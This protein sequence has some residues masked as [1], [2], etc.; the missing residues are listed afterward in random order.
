MLMRRTAE[1]ARLALAP[2]VL[3]AFAA[4]ASVLG[5][6]ERTLDTADSYPPEGYD[7]CRPGAD[8][9]GCLDV[10]HAECQARAACSAPDS[11]GPCGQCVCGSCSEPVVDCQLDPGCAAI[12]EC[13]QGSR[14]ELSEGAASCAQV[15]GEV[16]EDNGGVRGASFLA[17]A[18][19]RT[20]AVTSSCLSCLPASPEPPATCT[21]ANGCDACDSCFRQCL[22][23]GERFGVCQEACGEDA[24]PAAC[25][26][27]D[28]C[29]GCDTCFVTCACHGG[30]FDECTAE[31]QAPEPCTAATSCADCGDCVKQCECQGG[32]TVDCEAACAPPSPGEC[33]LTSRG[34]RS[35]RCDGCT[36]CVAD[37]VCEGNTPEDCMGRCELLECCAT[38][39]CAAALTYCVCAGSTLQK[40]A[41]DAY[42][43]CDDARGCDACPCNSCGGSYRL[44]EET[45]GC[46]AIFDCMRTSECHGSTCSERC[47]SASP[48]AAPEAFDIAELLWACVQAAG[49]SCDPSTELPVTCGTT[50]CQ[51]YVGSNATLPAC[52]ATSSSASEE[53]SGA[54]GL[55]LSAHFPA[56]TACVPLGQQNPPREVLESCTESLTILDAPYNGATLP[57]CCRAADSVCGY[58]DEITG[59]GCVAPGIFNQP[60]QRCAF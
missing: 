59:L 3:V 1:L 31:C 26:E 21:P 23:S 38:Q 9:T 13:L 55:D 42:P 39:S 36:S 27:E 4:C 7:G 37:C 20:C 56:A 17:A 41:G 58:W 16:I 54:C 52:C 44:C 47:A 18:A 5:I 28:A 46:P 34:S 22:C 40:C 33:S 30:E 11:L 43:S 50:D 35:E 60:S 48:S 45:S 12:W 6:E 29:Q 57:G 10:H 15:C 14:C 24:P 25:S 2:L 32:T 8:C 53:T 19:I 49:C 51:P